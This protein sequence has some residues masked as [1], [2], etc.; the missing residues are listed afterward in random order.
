[1]ATGWDQTSFSSE[2]KEHACHKLPL[3]L[4]L[5]VDLEVADENRVLWPSVRL[6]NWMTPGPCINHLMYKANPAVMKVRH[7]DKLQIT[8]VYPFNKIL[9]AM[10]LKKNNVLF[11]YKYL[12]STLYLETS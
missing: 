5:G 7:Q 8:S 6:R 1:M 4:A 12:L 3:S 9:L 2:L 10:I 11:L